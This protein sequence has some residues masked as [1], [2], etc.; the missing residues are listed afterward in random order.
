MI[1]M[2][3]FLVTHRLAAKHSKQHVR[4]RKGCGHCGALQKTADVRHA[5]SAN[6]LQKKIKAG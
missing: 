5:G 2:L 6:G 4:Q 1:V 3:V